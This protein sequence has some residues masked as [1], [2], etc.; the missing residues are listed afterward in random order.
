MA[1]SVGHFYLLWV[2][3]CG[4]FAVGLW[5]YVGCFA[6]VA[7]G[8]LLGRSR[9]VAVGQLLQ[10]LVPLLRALWVDSC[11]NWSLLVGRSVL[12]DHFI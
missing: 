8:R 3:R 9:S 6:L 2:G 7:V 11:V 5:L 1:L 4:F 12:V 10:R